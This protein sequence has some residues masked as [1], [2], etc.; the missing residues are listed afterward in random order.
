MLRGEI[1]VWFFLNLGLISLS[2]NSAF[3]RTNVDPQFRYDLYTRRYWG[4]GRLWLSGYYKMG[5]LMD[6]SLEQRKHDLAYWRS[7]GKD[8]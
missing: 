4:A 1:P 3:R 6:S 7:Q 5:E 8:V 2:F